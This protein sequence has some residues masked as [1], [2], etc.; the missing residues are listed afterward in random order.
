MKTKLI[1]SLIM[2]TAVCASSQDK[3]VLYWDFNSSEGRL[4]KEQK[5]RP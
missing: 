3:P 2:L 1:A 4:I 5:S